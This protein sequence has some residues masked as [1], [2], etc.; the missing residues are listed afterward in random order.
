MR[1]M[2]KAQ[3]VKLWALVQANLLDPLELARLAKEAHK[4]SIPLCDLLIEKTKLDYN[5]LRAATESF[6]IVR[7]KRGEEVEGMKIT[8]ALGTG[9]LGICYQLRDPSSRQ[10]FSCKF[11]PSLFLRSE[12]LR[13]RLNSTLERLSNFRSE[14]S[15][16]LVR[17]K[18]SSD[19]AYAIQE[20]VRGRSVASTFSRTH[21]TPEKDALKLAESVLLAL[22]DLHSAGL[23]HGS[24]HP[25]NIIV[26]ARWEVKL[27]DG[28]LWR[29]TGWNDRIGDTHF[30]LR[31]H[32]L[33]PEVAR[34]EEPSPR[35]D[36][37]SLGVIL[38][39]IIT[40][41]LP[42]GEGIP[43]IY[44]A[45]TLTDSPTPP[46]ELYPLLSTR[47]N[48][49]IL[50]LLSRRPSD[51]PADAG[52]ALKFVRETLSGTER[53]VVQESVLSEV[54]LKERPFFSQSEPKLQPKRPSTFSKLTLTLAI[55]FIVA[56]FAGLYLLF[57]K[58]NKPTQATP[59]TPFV[60]QELPEQDPERVQSPPSPLS[61][62]PVVT[63]AQ[64]KLPPPSS[65]SSL[66]WSIE[67]PSEKSPEAIFNELKRK[68]D[69]LVEKHRYGDALKLYD[70]FPRKYDMTEWKR[71]VVKEKQL[72]LRLASDRLNQL[73]KSAERAI[74]L[75]DREQLERLC[76]AI[77]SLPLKDVDRIASELLNRSLAKN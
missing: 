10:L 11:F 13:Q 18:L 33:A 29:F 57:L 64:P 62:A 21:P 52:E 42:L 31:F 28:G 63:K 55:L 37:Y 76:K 1:C 23:V 25:R 54:D 68:A 2:Q 36:L 9:G 3:K 6:P 30:P 5:D 22:K 71:M 49:L 19:E 51:R 75:G 41:V 59:K 50:S 61:P 48:S 53:F 35:S 15:C 58:A 4:Q 38:Y 47:T 73:R 26:S 44:L 70:T 46:N 69:S 74:T 32:F 27:T 40:G 65:S 60:R 14:F 45:R 24:L 77:R 43:A 17:Y 7:K 20:Y 67:K 12:P 66:R 34:G 16:R 56:V 72:V 39:F 8:S